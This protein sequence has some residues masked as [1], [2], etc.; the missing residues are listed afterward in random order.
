[1]QIDK[2]GW[3]YLANYKIC[4]RC[5]NY[6]PISDYHKTTHFCSRLRSDKVNLVTG[7]VEKIERL[8]DCEKER[9]DTNPECCG[10]EGIFFKEMIQNDRKETCD[11][12][13]N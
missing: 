10:P 8:L 5:D 9:K 1:L 13:R 4:I 3:I 7:E 11:C 2:K 12:T 6:Y